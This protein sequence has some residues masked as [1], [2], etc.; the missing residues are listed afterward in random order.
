M[1]PAGVRGGPGRLAGGS[2]ARPATPRTGPPARPIIDGKP[3]H[4]RAW[5]DGT[6]VSNYEAP[7]DWVP[8]TLTADQVREVNARNAVEVEL[9]DEA[10]GRVLARVAERGWSDDVDVVVHHR[11]R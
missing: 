9:I 5:Y 4:W 11:P 6:L 10:L 1:G 3:R 8:A 7:A 2:A